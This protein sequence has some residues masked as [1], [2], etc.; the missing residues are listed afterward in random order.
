VV[1]ADVEPGKPT[2]T[3]VLE[4]AWSTIRTSL[5]AHATSIDTTSIDTPELDASSTA[6]GPARLQL[7]VCVTTDPRVVGGKPLG[8]GRWGQSDLAGNVFEWM[9]DTFRDGCL[10][11]DA[12]LHADGRPELPPTTIEPVRA[13]RAHGQL[14]DQP[15]A[16]EDLGDARHVDQLQRRQ[17]LGRHRPDVG[18]SARG[19]TRQA[20]RAPAAS[21]R[22]RG[23]DRPRP[24]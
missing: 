1:A 23:R 16:A 24:R 14:Q 10:V 19:D 7:G 22:L 13:L 17:Q 5:W 6:P 9:P 4:T 12:P 3:F 11:T 21:H 8:D 15:E 2:G 20:A 18:S